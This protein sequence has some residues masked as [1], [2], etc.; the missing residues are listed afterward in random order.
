MN[1]VKSTIIILLGFIS[2]LFS[3][4]WYL[5]IDTSPDTYKMLLSI[6]GLLGIYISIQYYRY[7]KY[8]RKVKKK[9]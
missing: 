2:F 4:Y 1:K 3:G 5:S 8:K 9:K 7:T 6:L